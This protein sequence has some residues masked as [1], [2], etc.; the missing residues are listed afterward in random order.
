MDPSLARFEERSL[1]ETYISKQL[2]RHMRT[3]WCKQLVLPKALLCGSIA[4]T[5]ELVPLRKINYICARSQKKL[6]IFL[7]L[8][9]C[10]TEVPSL[11]PI[12]RA[13]EGM[14]HFS[15]R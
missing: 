14:G 5:R 3:T 8:Y 11:V 15:E 9:Q 12:L 1:K 2:E 13:C 4:I 6:T 10:G 7:F